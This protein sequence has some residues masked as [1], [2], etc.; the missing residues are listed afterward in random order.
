MSFRSPITTQGADPRFLLT[1]AVLVLAAGSAHA[2][3]SPI[4]GVQLAADESFMTNSADF[5][6]SGR[7]LLSSAS[8][9]SGA[10]STSR[11]SHSV[12]LGC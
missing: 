6:W 11:C 8:A 5:L 9:N 1:A 12:S 7:S 2:Q 10:S 4:Y 3:S